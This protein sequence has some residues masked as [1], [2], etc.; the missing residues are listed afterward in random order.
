LYSYTLNTQVVEPYNFSRAIEVAVKEFAPDKLIILGP[1][2]T[3]GGSVA[4]CLIV[5]EWL[6]LNNKSDFIQLQKS[7]PY[8]LAMGLSEQR[9]HLI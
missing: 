8:L 1:G 4:Q 6:G 3:L 7:T 2:S 9:K 5:Q